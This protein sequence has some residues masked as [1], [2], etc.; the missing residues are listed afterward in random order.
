M[1]RFRLAAAALAAGVVAGGF[2]EPPVSPENT[3]RYSRGRGGSCTAMV[4]YYGPQALWIGRFAGG[5]RMDIS[6]ERV[7]MDWQVAESCFFDL[8]DCNRWIDGLHRM[9]PE[10]AGYAF[11]RSLADVPSGPAPRRGGKAVVKP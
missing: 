6:A 4:P 1:R 2:T 11:C 7:F 9:Y 5:R 10:G 3:L 8:V